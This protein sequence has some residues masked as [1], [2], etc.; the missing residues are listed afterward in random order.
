MQDFKHIKPISCEYTQ[1]KDDICFLKYKKED[2][3]YKEYSIH[4]INFETKN[5]RE[6]AIVRLYVTKSR[7]FYAWVRII[8]KNSGGAKATGHGYDK[9]S[10]AIYRA[11]VSAGC[12]F[13]ASFDGTGEHEK[14]LHGLALALAEPG[15]KVFL[16]SAHA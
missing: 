4:A 15:E 16:H 9:E 14:G 6:L 11:L 1:T 10:S 2:H 5:T 12:K 7:T 3:F 13:A 8:N